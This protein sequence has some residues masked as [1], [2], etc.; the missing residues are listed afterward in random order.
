MI[1]WRTFNA[2]KVPGQVKGMIANT[3]TRQ[4]GKNKFVGAMKGRF[5][6]RVA[7]F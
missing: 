4:A 2:M 5:I 6:I 7:V 1:E 3:A